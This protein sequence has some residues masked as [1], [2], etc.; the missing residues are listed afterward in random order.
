MIDDSQLGTS[1]SRRK[2]VRINFQILFDV[3]S[4]MTVLSTARG[5]PD[6]GLSSKSVPPFS[7]RADQQW[8]IAIKVVSSLHV[9][10]VANGYRRSGA[11]APL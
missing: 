4:S 10:N 3:V 5:R 7:E 8:P 11:A 6:R 1:M 9:V 2:T